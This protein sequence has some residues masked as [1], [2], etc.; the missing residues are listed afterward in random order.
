MAM[1]VVIA[2]VL[3]SLVV[4]VWIGSRFSKSPFVKFFDRNDWFVGIFL[5]LVGYMNFA[6]YRVTYIKNINLVLIVIGL[7]LILFSLID[8]FK[9]KK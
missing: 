7:V 4:G 1:N 6:A 2:Q 8:I 3:L 5:V 9:A